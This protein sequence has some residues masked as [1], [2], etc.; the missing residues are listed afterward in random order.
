MMNV[1]IGVL[2]NE[3]NDQKVNSRVG[4]LKLR[5]QVLVQLLE[6]REMLPFTR[7]LSAAADAGQHGDY[8]GLWILWAPEAV[9]QAQEDQEAAELESAV[10]SL[11]AKLD[12]M[13][14][15]VADVCRL[16]PLTF[17]RGVSG[18]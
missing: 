5:A 1:Y 12:R 9:G 18:Y 15:M 2:G 8:E 4:T 10:G 6:V 14:K 17:Q 11:E 3:Y 16:D 13:E 7:R